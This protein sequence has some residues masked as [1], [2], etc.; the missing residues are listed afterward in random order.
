MKTQHLLQKQ[1]GVALLEVL[2]AIVVMALGIIGSVGLQ[3]K[4]TAA[5]SDAGARAEAVIASEKLIGLMWNDQQNLASY[6]WAGSGT[7]PSSLAGWVTETRAS[8]PN[9]T[10][11]ITVTPQA[12]GSTANQVGIT[13]RW[14]RRSTDPVSNHTLTATLATTS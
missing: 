14:Q 3:A 9:A 12:A 13:I 10:M 4:A 8:L 6:A 7:A 11:N 5:M 2:I 1:A